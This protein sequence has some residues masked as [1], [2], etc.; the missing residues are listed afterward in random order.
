LH[1]CEFKVPVARFPISLPN[2]LKHPTFEII[3]DL[4]LIDAALFFAFFFLPPSSVIVPHSSSGDNF[5]GRFVLSPRGP[6]RD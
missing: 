1:V 5:I 6:N 3:S 4:L 2:A